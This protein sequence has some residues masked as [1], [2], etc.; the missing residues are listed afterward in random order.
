MNVIS[1]FHTH[2]VYSDGKDTPEDIILEALRLGCSAI[3]F[4]DDSYTAFDPVRTP[5]NISVK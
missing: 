2:T 5:P 4:S 1:N 3:G